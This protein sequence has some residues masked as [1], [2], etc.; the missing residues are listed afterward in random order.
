MNRIL[1]LLPL[2]VLLSACATTG[3]VESPYPP[4]DA[5]PTLSASLFPSDQSVISQAAIDTILQ[6]RVTLPENTKAALINFS[7]VTDS[8]TYGYGYS[9]SEAVMKMQQSY[10]DH[11]SSGLMETGFLESVV[12]LPSMLTP[13]SPTIP[14]LRE[15]AVRVQS[16]ILII[17]QI[18]S[19]TYQEYRIFR[20]SRAKA[21]ATI[22]FVLLD[23]RTGIIPFTAI[24][25]EEYETEK[26]DSDSNTEEMMKRA[27][28]EATLRA[29][30]QG[31][32]QFDT[33]FHLNS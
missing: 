7:S 28:N 19:D 11:L 9:R 6:S 13:Q 22:E 24:V 14:V 30:A 16:P 3:M 15:A 17:F 33:F 31:V 10:I 27:E 20:S 23:V 12:H 2:V 1:H 21:Y 18:Q 5:G 26:N 32:S 4:M 29:L 8:N 25:T